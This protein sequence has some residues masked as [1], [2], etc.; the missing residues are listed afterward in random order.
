MNLE[1]IINAPRSGKE[2]QED[3]ASILS[4]LK[5]LNMKRAINYDGSIDNGE[6]EFRIDNLDEPDEVC[7]SF[8]SPCPI[9]LEVYNGAAVIS[10]IHRY[11]FLYYHYETNWFSDFRKNLFDVSQIIGATEGIFSY[12]MSKY[13]CDLVMMGLP[14]SEVKKQMI[15]ELGAPITDY[16]QL[17]FRENEPY[18]PDEFFLERFEDLR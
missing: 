4:Q 3:W 10:S 13:V 1:F 16:K 9:S 11:S 7:V 8:L 5:G 18:P 17:V 14:Y 2:T 6:W 15:A 12:D